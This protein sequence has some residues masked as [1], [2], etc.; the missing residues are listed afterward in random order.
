MPAP[1]NLSE[2]LRGQVIPSLADIRRAVA[3]LRARLSSQKEVPL[4]GHL[5]DL[6]QDLGA[7]RPTEERVDLDADW[8]QS[9]EPWIRHERAKA[10]LREA[11]VELLVLGEAIPGAGWHSDESARF[12]WARG[13]TSSAAQVGL[14]RVLYPMLLL[15]PASFRSQ[16]QVA[17][18]PVSFLDQLGGDLPI[19]DHVRQCLKEAVEAHRRHLPLAAGIMVGAASEGTWL[20]L[21]EVLTLTRQSPTIIQIRAELDKLRPSAAA[22]QDLVAD[23]LTESQNRQLATRTG[24]P[25]QD[26]RARA[27]YYRTLRNY[28]HPHVEQRP[29]PDFENMSMALLEAGRYFRALYQMIRDLRAEP[30]E[31]Q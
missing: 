28:A 16:E 4:H 7:P 2:D 20:E 5:E 14:P 18:S 25:P 15:Q 31:T 21:A 9:A 12:P 13:G 3:A 19:S 29:S 30:G 23:F 1:E 27:E 22:I 8:P 6:A 11:S 24:V 10:A 26:L 17:V